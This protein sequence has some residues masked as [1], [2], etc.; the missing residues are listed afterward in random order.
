MSHYQLY[1]IALIMFFFLCFAMSLVV[2]ELYNDENADDKDHKYVMIALVVIMLLYCTQW[3]L[4]CGY[5][6]ARG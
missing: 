3:C 4:P 6:T 2:M 5:R 1:K